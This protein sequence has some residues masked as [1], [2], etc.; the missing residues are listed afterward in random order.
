MEY[1]TPME[2]ET[3]KKLYVDD[4]RSPPD[5]TW[6]VARNFHKAISMLEDEIYDIVSLDNDIASFYGNRE[7]MGYDILQWLIMCKLEG[8]TVPSTVLV[9]SANPVQHEKMQQDIDRYFS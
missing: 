1:G 8:H 5:D 2:N 7:M 3:L 6:D 9:H 4:L